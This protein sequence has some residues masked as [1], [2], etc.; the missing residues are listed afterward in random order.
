M[1]KPLTYLAAGLITPAI[2]TG[3]S[4]SDPL[5][6]LDNQTWFLAD[7]WENGFPFLNRWTKD[8]A[9]FNDE[10]LT[11]TLKNTID[12]HGYK[13]VVSGEIRSYGYYGNG[14]FEVEMK[15]VKA[16]GVV[17]AFFLFAGPYDQPEGGNGIHNE[18]DIEFLGMNTNLVQL[19]FW[20][21]DENYEQHNEYIHYLDFDASEDFHTY[22][23]EWNK[24]TIKWFIDGELVYRVRNTDQ[25]PI[26]MK[27]DNRLRI[28]M[29][30][31]ATNPQISNWAGTYD[32]TTGLEH[33][34]Q[35]RNFKYTRA[36]CNR[37]K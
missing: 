32:D 3:A 36:K 33:S 17:S 19:N 14:C 8:Q 9:L 28:M 13:D 15:P 31:W 26:P 10:G 21:N 29:N 22:A 5:S 18:I 23:I 11:L 25:Q 34:A 2:A 37:R 1:L 35:F 12:D 6:E 24:N 30:V 4:F 16:D 20:T 27:S 7:G